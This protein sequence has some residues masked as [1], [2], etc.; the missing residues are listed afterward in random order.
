MI[1]FFVCV[2]L[3]LLEKGKKVYCDMIKVGIYLDRILG[4]ILIDMYVKCGNIR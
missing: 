3:R 1:I 2:S 4:N